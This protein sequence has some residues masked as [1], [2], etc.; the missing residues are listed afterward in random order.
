MSDARLHS[1]R[2]YIQKYQDMC[3]S[4]CTYLWHPAYG[5]R[6]EQ[7]FAESPGN[8]ELFLFHD[9]LAAVGQTVA[10]VA[11][12]HGM[13]VDGLDFLWSVEDAKSGGRYDVPNVV[14]QV[15]LAAESVQQLRSG[16]RNHDDN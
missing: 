3:L 10:A 16:D 5:R 7:S 4:V 15:G 2:V 9:W 1:V 13:L 6:L 12:A 14:W 11:F 8:P